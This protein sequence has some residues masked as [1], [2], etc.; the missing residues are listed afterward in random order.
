MA[1]GMQTGRRTGVSGMRTGMRTGATQTGNGGPLGGISKKWN[2]MDPK[3]KTLIIASVVVVVFIAIIANIVATSNKPVALYP[4]TI[5]SRDSEEIRQK[6]LQWGIDCTLE[7]GGTNVLVHPKYKSMALMKLAEEGLPRRPVET[8]NQLLG[9]E[10][11][12]MV[13][14]TKDDKERKVL[15]A[16][17]GDLITSIRQIE[18][19]A[20]AYV[21]IV[22]EP[23]KV[24]GED[25]GSASASIMLKFYPNAKL[26]R[27]QIDGII[28]LVTASVKGLK[29][30]N[31]KVLDTSG[32]LLN[33]GPEDG[34]AMG[35]EGTYTN[36]QIL[37][38]ENTEKQLKQKVQN[39]LNK[40]LG[41]D[42]FD[43]A[44]NVDMDFSEEEIKSTK[45]GGP[46]NTEGKVEAGLSRK[47]ETYNTDPDAG[48][49]NDGVTELSA[50]DNAQGNNYKNE[51]VTIRS[52]V[53]KVERRK[54]VTDPKIQ[55]V[56]CSV[57]VD[58]VKEPEMIARLEEF[59]K[60]AIGHDPSR[61]DEVAIVP[62]PISRPI[63]ANG[64]GEQMAAMNFPK[65]NDVGVSAPSWLPLLLL[66][67]VMLGILLA[68]VFYMKQKSVQREKQRLVLSSG[69]GATVSDISDLMADKEGKVTPPPSTKVNTTDQLED[70]A[71]EK[72]TK[73][74]ELL[75]ST[76]LADK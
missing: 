66:I 49:S 32:K 22:P 64:N 60:G 62:F 57:M 74:A 9:G 58:G 75:K 24:F 28:H 10:S 11:G 26:S 50:G 31:V 3:K 15:M 48:S 20:D 54:V 52:L 68:A 13:P 51:S 30:E 43:V 6:L 73:V 59:V 44:V 7:A 29:T 19:I 56:T 53:D 55:R 45:Y 5:D 23:E 41:E 8:T 42:K 2:D 14:D 46:T 71:K 65:N 67:P 35:E 27:R 47:T 69:P 33:T 12:G 37:I 25:K 40:F 21:K 1:T 16:L 70:L 34:V 63:T 39:A 18:G 4:G 17:E 72:P 76:W 36:E 61:G 38:R